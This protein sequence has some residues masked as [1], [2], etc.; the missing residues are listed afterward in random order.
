ML[1]ACHLQYFPSKGCNLMQHSLFSKVAAPRSLLKTLNKE[2]DMMCN[3]A[4]EVLT[5]GQLDSAPSFVLTRVSSGFGFDVGQL[6]W[7]QSTWGGR[8]RRVKT[9]P[10]TMVTRLPWPPKARRGRFKSSAPLSSRFRLAT[11]FRS[12]NGVS[13]GKSACEPWMCTSFKA[14][15]SIK[16]F[17]DSSLFIIIYN[18]RPRAPPWVPGY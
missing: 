7:F 14:S 4:S 8:K 10:V 5:V 3:D 12:V 6:L 16:E 1:K 11:H 2:P 17:L 9:P 15:V 18:Y 13:K